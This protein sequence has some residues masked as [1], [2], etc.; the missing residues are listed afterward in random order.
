MT[1]TATPRFYGKYRGKVHDNVDPL[2]LGRI[3]AEV[4]AI[5][6]SN[7]NWAMPC[8]PYAGPGVGFYAI[9]PIGA[10]VWVEFEGGDP[11]YP[12]WV[13]CFWGEGEIVGLPDPPQ[14][15]IKIF[16]TDCC[17]IV[18]NDSP[19][20][21]GVSIQCK[22]PSFATPLTF[23]FNSEGITVACPDSTIKVTPAGITLNVQP[24]AIA[25][26]QT[27]ITLS[28]PDPLIE[29]VGGQV[30]IPHLKTAGALE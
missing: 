2:L 24:S 29:I 12:I 26:E 20:V 17:S 10:N 4:P 25:V 8:S 21:G 30:F 7:L 5:A 11:N 19:E 28:A 9:P 18:L 15:E 23:L 6:G 3:M 27:I 16:Q 14:P 22:P 13:G 1:P